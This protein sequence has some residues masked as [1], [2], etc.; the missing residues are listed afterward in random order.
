M[1][2]IAVFFDNDTLR[3]QALW[4]KEPLNETSHELINYYYCG[5]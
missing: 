1:E 3:E 5:K 2:F 4:S